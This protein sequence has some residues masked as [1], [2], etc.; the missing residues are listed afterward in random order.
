GVAGAIPVRPS[1]EASPE[2]SSGARVSRP[3]PRAAALAVA[4]AIAVVTLRPAPDL[5]AVAVVAAPLPAGWTPVTPTKIERRFAADHGA[6]VTK[7]VDPATGA[8]IVQ[9]ASA[10]W[11]AQHVPEQCL[12]ASGWTVSDDRPVAIDGLGWVRSATVTRDGRTA[13]ALWWF[14]SDDRI[15]DDLVVRILDGR[16]RWVLVSLLAPTAEAAIAAARDVARSSVPVAF[17]DGD[18]GASIQEGS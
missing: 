13:S 11:A 1:R 18:A 6:V 8:S 7:G 14:Q 2:R 16:R 4:V 10:S 3:L 17:T 5:P 9:V 12:R 15:T